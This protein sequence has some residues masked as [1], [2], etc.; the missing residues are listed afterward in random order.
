[1]GLAKIGLEKWG[2]AQPFLE[3]AVAYEPSRPEPRTRLGLALVMLDQPDKARA[4]REALIQLDISCNKTCADATWIEARYQVVLGDRGRR[5]R[6]VGRRE[7]GQRT[8]ALI[9]AWSPR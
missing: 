4:Q 3:T 2:E 9:P 1:M 7:L 5:W 8:V 6:I